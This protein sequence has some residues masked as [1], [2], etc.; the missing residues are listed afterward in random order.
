[1]NG[2]QVTKGEAVSERSRDASSVETRGKAEKR[3]LNKPLFSMKVL[4]S[5]YLIAFKYVIRTVTVFR[6]YV[7]FAGQG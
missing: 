6:E 5:V 3:V 1:M 7:N 2:I 4:E